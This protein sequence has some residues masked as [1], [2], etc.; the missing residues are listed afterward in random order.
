[1]F[2]FHSYIDSPYLFRRQ[3]E[4]ESFF[5]SVEKAAVRKRVNAGQATTNAP[6]LKRHHPVHALGERAR[7]WVAHER[8]SRPPR[9]PAGRRQ[10]VNVKHTDRRC[11]AGSRLPVGS[12]ANRTRRIADQRAG[13][14]HALLLPAG[15]LRRAVSE[16]RAKPQLFHP[17]LRFGR[18]A[19]VALPSD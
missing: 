13:D 16:T 10:R 2:L 8:S 5:N 1:M 3:T 15:E 14:G 6:V 18:G 11:G 17:V 12:S 4:S 7:L 19:F 9:L